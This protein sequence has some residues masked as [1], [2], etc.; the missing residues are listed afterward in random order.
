M[1]ETTEK[2][3]FTDDETIVC[4]M[5]LK[6]TFHQFMSFKQR[7]IPDFH[8]NM[9]LLNAIEDHE[10]CEKTIKEHLEETD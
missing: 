3:F 5:G 1:K 7:H 4:F 6:E 8:I 10:H 9:T 2:D